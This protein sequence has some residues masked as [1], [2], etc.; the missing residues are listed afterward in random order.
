MTK[1]S[2]K[3]TPENTVATDKSVTAI[4]VESNIAPETAEPTAPV[5]ERA[6]SAD[7]RVDRALGI[8]SDLTAL[9]VAG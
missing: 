9:E 1:E 4:A 2:T 7:P 3:R 6:E 8:F 5:A